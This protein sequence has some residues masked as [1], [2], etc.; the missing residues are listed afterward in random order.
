[1]L[2]WFWCGRCCLA[3]SLEGLTLTC[4]AWSKKQ[5]L[6]LPHTWPALLL[7]IVLT[8]AFWIEGLFCFA[9]YCPP[10]GRCH[11]SQK[12]EN[13]QWL[14]TILWVSFKKSDKDSSHSLELL[15]E[16]IS[17]TVAVS[18]LRGMAMARSSSPLS[19]VKGICSH[20]VDELEVSHATISKTHG[21][22]S[23]FLFESLS[24]ASVHQGRGVWDSPNWQSW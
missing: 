19:Y 6:M 14:K 13:M 10:T 17:S 3:L 7:M 24:I 18:L 5:V 20:R 11:S 12:H 2:C 22:Y 15:K 9:L 23:F 16:V 21:T 4:L 1:M 8:A